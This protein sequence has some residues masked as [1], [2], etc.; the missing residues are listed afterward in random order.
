VK[1][2]GRLEVVDVTGMGQQRKAEIVPTIPIE[3]YVD[4]AI[5]FPQAI[6]KPRDVQNGQQVAEEKVNILKGWS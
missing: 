6:D 2:E 1:S 5:W 4:C 3:S